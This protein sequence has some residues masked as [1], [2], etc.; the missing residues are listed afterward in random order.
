[1]AIFENYRMGTSET[2]S[3]GADAQVLADLDAVMKRITTGK[4]LDAK[5][6]LRIE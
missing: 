6:S 3:A 4:P 2:Q 1:M 5:S